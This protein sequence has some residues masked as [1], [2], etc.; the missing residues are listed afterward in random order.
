M[1]GIV[2]Q[3]EGVLLSGICGFVLDLIKNSGSSLTYSTKGTIPVRL[4]DTFD[5][6]AAYQLRLKNG[7]RKK[8]E[9]L[10]LHLRAGSAQLNIVDYSAPT[11]LHLQ[12]EPDGGGIKIPL[13]YLKPKDSLRVQVVAKGAYVPGTLDVDVSSPNKINVKRVEDLDVRKPF[14]RFTFICFIAAVVIFVAFDAGKATE[15]TELAKR[16]SAP[17]FVL[18]RKMVLVSAA[19]D[20]KLPNLASALANASDLT[21]YEAGDLAYSQATT[22]TKPEEIDRYRRFISLALGP[23][24]SIADES[25]ANLFYC[26]GKLDLLRSDERS[27]IADFKTSIAKSKSIIQSRAKSDPQ[28]Q[29]FLIKQSLL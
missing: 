5:S 22:T 19:A 6:V 17:S 29:D 7:S 24:H 25:Q 26:L 23:D 1:W 2:S 10:T 9:D 14:W 13:E 4:P 3:I 12:Q 27:A 18:D 16:Q 28:T 8:A 21:Y 11:G 15:V 20:S